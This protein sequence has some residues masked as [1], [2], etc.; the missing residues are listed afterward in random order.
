MKSPSV[1]IKT[2]NIP[3]VCKTFGTFSTSASFG[4]THFMVEA[5]SFLIFKKRGDSRKRS[6]INTAAAD[7]ASVVATGKSAFCA[8]VPERI[9]PNVPPITGPIIRPKSEASEFFPNLAVMFAFDETSARYAF[10][11]ATFPPVSPSKPLAT[12]NNKSG[13]VR[14]KVAI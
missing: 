10:A 12:N 6:M 2:K 11:T 3:I 14:V 5:P 1:K 13:R 9:D 4:F 7:I 8:S